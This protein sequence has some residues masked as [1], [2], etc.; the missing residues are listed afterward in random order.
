MF[1]YVKTYLLLACPSF[2]DLSNGKEIIKYVRQQ[3]CGGNDALDMFLSLRLFLI[4]AGQVGRGENSAEGC[5]EFMRCEG[6]KPGFQF[7]QLYFLF[8]G[9]IQKI[10]HPL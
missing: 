2:F 8:K 7:V 9:Y 4:F 10:I 5:S 6:N 3:I 1:L